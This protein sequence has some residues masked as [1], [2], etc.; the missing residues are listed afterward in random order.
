MKSFKNSQEEEI[1]LSHSQLA[2]MT[3]CN[4]AGTEL[5]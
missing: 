5:P 2:D 4:P 3:G 1:C